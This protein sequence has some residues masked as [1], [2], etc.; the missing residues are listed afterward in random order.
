[1]SIR[2]RLRLAAWL[3]E[4]WRRQSKPFPE[5]P[6]H[7]DLLQ[8]RWQAAWTALH[9]CQL[10][11]KHRLQLCLPSLRQALVSALSHLSAQIGVLSSCYEI[12]EREE[13]T[14]RHWYEEVVQ[15]EDEFLKV[16]FDPEEGRLRVETPVIT[17]TEV[18]LGA[19]AIDFRKEERELSVAS[20][21]IEALDPQPASK[22]EDVV[23]PHV[24]AGEIC[25]GEGKVPIRAALESGRLADA[26]LLVLS[27]L[28]TYNS[29]SAYVKL[30]EWHGVS[31][32]DCSII[33]SQDDSYLCH[34]CRESL[35]QNCTSSCS[36][37][38]ETF[39][40][41]CVQ[42]CSSCRTSCCEACLE[43]SEGSG[44]SLCQD[45]R[46]S[47]DQCGKELGL[48]EVD[49]AHLCRDCAKEADSGETEIDSDIVD[50]QPQE[51][52][53]E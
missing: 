28:K 45:C 30:E 52:S 32:F 39:C 47:C 51:V 11:I 24:K 50:D 27:V 49:D 40:P 29:R 20:F 3:Q 13:L 25:P 48:D 7:W 43:N 6:Y 37:C 4:L 15:L 9:R 41:E 8:S 46:T 42:G 23:H 10:A 26:F 18:Y 33:V 16:S 14:L 36:S 2:E 22:D 34:R 17:L 19:F 5:T 1:M 31:C 35:C 53:T 21:R 38:S 44:R 12:V